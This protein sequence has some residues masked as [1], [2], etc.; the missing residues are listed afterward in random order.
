MSIRPRTWAIGLAAVA[1]VAIAVVLITTLGPASASAPL[2]NP[3][4][5]D[6]FIMAAAGVSTNIGDYT[7]LSNSALRHL[8]ATNAESLRLLRTALTHEC[9]VP[10]DMAVTNNSRMAS[11][12]PRMKRLSQALAA[13]GLLYQR[14]NQPLQAAQ[15]YVDA[16]R[17]GNEISRGGVLINRLVGVA[18]EAIGRAPLAVDVP[19]LTPGQAR[20]VI[21][22]LE[23]IEATRVTWDEVRQSERRYVRRMLVHNPNPIMWAVGWWQNIGTMKRASERHYRIIA[24]ERLLTTELALRCYYADKACAPQRLEDLVP[25]YLS[26]VPQDPFTGRPMTYRAQGTNW[27]VYSVGPDRIDNGGRPAG[28]RPAGSMT[29]DLLYNAP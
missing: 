10:P 27:V 5:Y 23:K 16:I 13:E 3:N 20:Q 28:L 7:I 4:A 6:E 29:G 21:A 19:N 15:T 9:V 12:L 17:F 26:A 11:D 1:V 18:C 24:Q 2:P 22:G 14:D 8:V 25:G